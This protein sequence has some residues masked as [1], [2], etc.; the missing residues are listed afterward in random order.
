MISIPCHDGEWK[1]I[2]YLNSDLF[3]E[4]FETASQTISYKNR[5]ELVT[6]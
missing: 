5:L 2:T 4:A 6:Y 3:V 1:F